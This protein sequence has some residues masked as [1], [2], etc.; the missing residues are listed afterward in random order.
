MNFDLRLPLGLMFSIYGVV[1]IVMGLTT[2]KAIYE[3]SLGININL[4][5]GAVMLVFGAVMLFLS[6]RGRKAPE[7]HESSVEKGSRVGAKPITTDKSS[8]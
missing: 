6:L 8:V 2:D 1:L 3:K 5:W 7:P 4:I